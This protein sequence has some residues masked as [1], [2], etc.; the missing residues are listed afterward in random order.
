MST[1]KMG[2]NRNWLVANEGVSLAPPIDMFVKF[3]DRDLCT[4]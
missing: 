3:V 4:G 1:D 2:N